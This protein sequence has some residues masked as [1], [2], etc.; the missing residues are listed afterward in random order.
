VISDGHAT[1]ETWTA[2]R[3]I[4]IFT[5]GSKFED[6][7]TGCAVVSKCGDGWEGRKVFMRR[8]KEV[9]D[10]ELYA[11]WIRLAAARNHLKDD[12]AGA[13]SITLF[14]NA[15]AALNFQEDKERR[16]WPRTM[17]RATAPSHRTPTPSGWMDY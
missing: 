9:F 12:W 15:Q 2:D 14:T 13:K 11:I 7:Y 5:D 10:G 4:A 6:G 16:P 8:N 1:A 17:A 3:G